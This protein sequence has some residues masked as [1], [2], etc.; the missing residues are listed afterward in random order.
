LLANFVNETYSL[1]LD[2]LI[3][4]LTIQGHGPRIDVYELFS[5]YIAW[6]HK[7]GTMSSSSIKAWISTARS[8]LE[9]YDIDIN[10]RKFQ[11]KVRM[12]RVGRTEKTALSKEDIQN[13]L[14][15]CSSIKLKTYLL[16][17]AATG[18]RATE[19]LSIRL[20]DINFDKDPPTVYLRP[21]HTKTKTSPEIC[22]S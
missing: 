12:P 5:N 3:R 6:L 18:T 13:I 8:F 19:T 7:Q 21:E 4:T 14:N 10:S 22:F 1:S 9:T 20:C 17:L 2:E 11:L 15:A 16:F